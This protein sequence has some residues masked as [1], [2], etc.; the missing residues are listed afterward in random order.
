MQRFYKENAVADKITNLVPTMIRQGNKVPVFRASAAQ[1]RALIPFAAN[2]SAQLLSDNDAEEKAM[3]L[4]AMHLNECYKALSMQRLD[5]QQTL[6]EHSRKFATQFVALEAYTNHARLW[7]IR[8]KLRLFLELCL[9]GGKPSLCW[10]YRDEDF[11]GSCAHMSRRRGG[12]LNPTATSKTLLS[13][14]VVRQPML[15]I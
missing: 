9:D 4:A 5:F 7:R 10:T 13:R 8:P 14:F 3:R 11:G 2:L 15:H 12:L 6:E 1:V